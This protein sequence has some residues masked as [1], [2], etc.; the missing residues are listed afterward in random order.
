MKT[1]VLLIL[2]CI[3][4]FSCSESDSIEDGENGKYFIKLNESIS[5]TNSDKNL[6]YSG[7]AFSDEAIFKVG[8]ASLH[9]FEFYNSAKASP[10][11]IESKTYGAIIEF[12][13]SIEGKAS[14]V[15]VV[16]SGENILGENYDVEGFFK[17]KNG[18]EGSFLVRMEHIR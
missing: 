2:P 9:I 1:L 10:T 18:E 15:N 5:R 13:N 14:I 17:G 8:G 3:L 16:S 12:E 4:F 11:N 6:D 7:D